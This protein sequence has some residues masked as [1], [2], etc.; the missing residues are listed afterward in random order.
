MRR[1][2]RSSGHEGTPV[3]IQPPSRLL[4]RTTVYETIRGYKLP[5]S[6]YCSWYSLQYFRSMQCM[7]SMHGLY[8]VPLS[9]LRPTPPPTTLVFSPHLAC[10]ELCAPPVVNMAVIA[11]GI[12]ASAHVIMQ[13]SCISHQ[14]MPIGDFWPL[15]YLRDKGATAAQ[16][17]S[18]KG[19]G[20]GRWKGKSKCGVVRVVYWAYCT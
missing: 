5:C 16:P 17:Q 1:N 19:E 4:S 13:I 11:R 20:Q 15:Q 8:P 14:R 6:L 9:H 10:G 3:R 2:L 7:Q 18:R 12:R